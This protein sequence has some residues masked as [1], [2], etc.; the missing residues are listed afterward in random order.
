MLFRSGWTTNLA[1]LTCTRSDALLAGSGYPAITVTVS[2]ATNAAANVTNTA[3]VSGG[4][5]TNSAN[6]TASDATTINPSGGGG[7]VTLVGWDVSGQTNYGTSPL[8]PTTNAAHLTIG[9]LTRG[10]GVGTTGSGAARGWGG[11]NWMETTSA[12]AINSNRFVSFAVAA[13]GGY[14]VSFTSVGKF[15]YRH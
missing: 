6:N 2:V 3:S 8:P 13:N 14:K 4:G 12:A 15:D 5:D 9:E 10:A 1:T 11:N 7:L